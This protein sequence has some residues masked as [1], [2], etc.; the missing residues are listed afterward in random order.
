MNAP[1]LAALLDQNR[2]A[3]H[4]LPGVVGSGVGRDA[5]TPGEREMIHVYVAPGTDFDF[6]RREA[7]HLLQISSGV[8]VIAM[9]MPEADSD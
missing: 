2:E 4:R 3:L 7:E 8:D 5:A 9:E 6:I 1:R